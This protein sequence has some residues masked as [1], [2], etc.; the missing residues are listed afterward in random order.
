MKNK[1]FTLVEIMVVVAIIALLSAVSIPNFL[2]SRINANE[3]AAINSLRTLS[4]AMESFR[5][6]RNPPS[7]LG[8]SLNV[9][10]RSNPPYIDQTLGS[11]RK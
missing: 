1:G 9:L 4:T 6:T 8:A 7:Y 11:S 2:R 10:A 5:F 3:V